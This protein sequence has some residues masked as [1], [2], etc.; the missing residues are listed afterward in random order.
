MRLSAIYSDGMIFQ[1]NKD[2]CL[3]GEAVSG[4]VIKASIGDK[5]EEAVAQANNRFVIIL[6][7]FEAGGP[8][9]LELN[10]TDGTKLT[11]RDLW[12]GDVF[13]LG[14]QSN[15]ELPV[16]RTLDLYYEEVKDATY[17]QI[18]MFQLPKEE[19]FEGPRDLL[20]EGSWVAVDSKSVMDFSALGFY[21]AERK[22]KEDGVPVGLV[23][24]AVGGVHIETFMSEETLLKVGAKMREDTL[25]AGAEAVCRCDNNGVCKWCYEK[26]LIQN[27]DADYVRGVKEEEQSRSDAWFEQ[28]SRN[29]I[30]ISGAWETFEWTEDTEE[31]MIPG[32]W[33]DM[34][35]GRIY[36][37]VWLQ[38]TVE[39]PESFCN[40]SVELRLGTL[41]DADTTY[42]NGIM[43]GQTAYRY[44]PRRYKLASDVLKPGKNVITVRLIINGNVGGFKPD[45]PYCL[46]LGEQEI[47][48]EGK[49]NARIGTVEQKLPE[50][51]FFAWKPTALYNSMIYAVRHCRFAGILFYQGESDCERA[52]DYVLLHKTM[53]EE[54]RNLFGE[55]LPYIY[56]QLPYFAGEGKD[57]DKAWVRL[58]H[59]QEE[60]RVIPGTQ[61]VVLHDLGQ[62]NELHPQNKKAVAERFYEKWLLF[63]G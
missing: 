41:V 39:V 22:Y 12:A 10:A 27:K 2:L 35:L 61:M 14:G 55:E 18:R 48:L 3:Y 60:A 5:Q 17:P 1:R 46:K 62:Y 25:R 15:M 28:C 51:T 32:M 54:W 53:I 7:A 36:G 6:P 23:H 49:W 26:Q 57:G 56:A 8:Y 11:Y 34:P 37:S 30:G 43:V 40:R 9:T 4:T 63:Q 44:P 16:N 52:D 59:A 21:F 31:I 45:M 24:A 58:Q 50:S 19:L 42:V 29:D 38:R 20:D 13:L 47:S 33:D